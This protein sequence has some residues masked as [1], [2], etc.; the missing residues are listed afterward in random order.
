VSE[1]IVKSLTRLETK[2]EGIEQ[3]IGELKSD[4]KSVVSNGAMTTK[5]PV[6]PVTGGLVG[7]AAALWTGYL[8]ASGKA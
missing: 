1:E 8:Q 7:L 6:L 3:T 2:V 4:L 5:T